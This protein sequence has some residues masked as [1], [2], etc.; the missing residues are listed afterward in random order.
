M[1][2]LAEV[3]EVQSIWSP[4]GFEIALIVIGGVLT[5]ALIA[6]FAILL[7]RNRER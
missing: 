2:V 4:A 6:F 3:T 1:N 7:W 5:V